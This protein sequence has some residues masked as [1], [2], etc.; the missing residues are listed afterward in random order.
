MRFLGLRN[1]K[2]VFDRGFRESGIYFIT[3]LASDHRVYCDMDTDGGG[4]LV[5]GLSNDKFLQPT[6]RFF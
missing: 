1:C 6:N 5:S 3:T 4:W 2:D